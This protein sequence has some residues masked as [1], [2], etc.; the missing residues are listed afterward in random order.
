M[1][2]DTTNVSPQM[3]DHEPLGGP[4]ASG[5]TLYAISLLSEA[6]GHSVYVHPQ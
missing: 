3:M 5:V 2:V 1:T 4:P 6:G